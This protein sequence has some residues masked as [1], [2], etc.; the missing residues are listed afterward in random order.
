MQNELIEKFA[1]LLA[2]CA[3]TGNK[4]ALQKEAAAQELIKEAINPA[5]LIGAPLLGATAGGL[6]GYYGTDKAK[7]RKRNALYGALIGGLGGAGGAMLAPAASDAIARFSGKAAPT[8]PVASKPLPADGTFNAGRSTTQELAN[9]GGVL[10][11]AA[12]GYGY[13]KQLAELLDAHG[14][15]K[16]PPTGPAPMREKKILDSASLGADATERARNAKVL[17]GLLRSRGAKINGI[18]TLPSDLAKVRGGRLGRVGG[19]AAGGVV[20][21]LATDYVGRFLQNF[22][23]ARLGNAP[24]P[25]PETK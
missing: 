4:A 11:G 22:I 23:A 25:T 6:A 12:V 13:A 10:G 17:A 24:A 20:G 19:A 2:E 1:A 9:A 3:T 16:M 14:P 5:Y 7:K 18:G 21:G 8:G 15:G